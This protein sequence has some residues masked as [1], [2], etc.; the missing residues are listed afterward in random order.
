MNKKKI[1]FVL[2][3]LIILQLPLIVFISSFK[4]VGFNINFYEKEFEKYNPK[5]ENAALISDG[6]ILF[7]KNK[8]AKMNHITVFDEKEI[9]HLIDVKKVIHKFLFILNLSLFLVLSLVACLYFADNKK[10]FKNL[11]ISLLF[12]GVLTLITNLIV[13]LTIKDFDKAFYR[14]H[15]LFFKIG[16]WQFS[17][18][19]KL[20]IL[21]PREFWI[22]AVNKI[23][24]NVVAIA[25]ILIVAGFLIL[26]S[27]Y[28]IEK[29]QNV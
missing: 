3:F 27:I 7:L 2:A 18:G 22:D 28:L 8:D 20:I 1:I 23:L 24:L 13:Y 25:N 15:E 10:I 26:L 9:Q 4:A 17:A 19:S 6:L 21:F 5:V 11:G 16:T 29:Q 14:F 12:G